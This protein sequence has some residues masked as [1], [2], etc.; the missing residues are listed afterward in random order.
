MVFLNGCTGKFGVQ[1][2]P[3]GMTLPTLDLLMVIDP[4]HK[5][6]LHKF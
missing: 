1:R 6:A 4:I 2:P 3:I 5:H